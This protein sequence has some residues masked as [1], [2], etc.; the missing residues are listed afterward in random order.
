M[1]ADT[2]LQI[3]R[4]LPAPIR[5]VFDAWTDPTQMAR[6]FFAGE[7][8]RAEVTNE[9]RVGGQ[10]SVAM[11]TDTGVRLVCSGVYQVIEPPARLVFTWSS[12]AV[13]DTLVTLALRDIGGSTELTLSH[14]G[15]VDAAIRE[16]HS[17]GWGGCLASLERYLAAA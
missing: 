1:T 14:E 13:T 17:Q 15:L 2:P 16:S 12:Y 7:N 6:W 10:F 3:V 8:W 11:I 4:V 5:K 9:L